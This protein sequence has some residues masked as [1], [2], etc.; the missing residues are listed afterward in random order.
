VQKRNPYA[1]PASFLSLFL[2]DP[3]RPFAPKATF[4]P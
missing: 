1:R 3:E 4:D 2:V